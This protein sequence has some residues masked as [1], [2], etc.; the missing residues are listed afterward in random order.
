MSNNFE[1]ICQ[2]KEENDEIQT[3]QNQFRFHP[4]FSQSNNIEALERKVSS[5]VS[6]TFQNVCGLR[7]SCYALKAFYHLFNL[8]FF[9][10]C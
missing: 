1:A 10:V 8:L 4:D 2:I 6:A 3:D 7:L 5:V 9:T